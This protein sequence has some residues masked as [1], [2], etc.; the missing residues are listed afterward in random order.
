MSPPVPLWGRMPPVDRLNVALAGFYLAALVTGEVV[1]AFW[2]QVAGTTI[3][4]LVLGC[5]LIDAS[6]GPDEGR[7][8]LRALLPIPLARIVTLG[9]PAGHDG[10]GSGVDVSWQALLVLLLLLVG[11]EIALS[12]GPRCAALVRNLRLAI[13]P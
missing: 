8:V 10:A 3:S 6:C 11:H 9:L 2:S 7:W 1:G 5:L 4:V 12:L 13:G